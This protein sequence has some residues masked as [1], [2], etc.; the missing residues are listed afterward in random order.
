ML[1]KYFRDWDNRHR[2][3]VVE[4]DDGTIGAGFRLWYLQYGRLLIY[5][6]AEAGEEVDGL[7]IHQF[8]ESD[9]MNLLDMSFDPYSRPTRDVDE[10][11]RM[12]YRSVI[13]I[14]D[15]IL[16]MVL[17]TPTRSKCEDNKS[18]AKG[19]DPRPGGKAQAKG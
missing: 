14:G 17:S 12:S 9:I 11:G 6:E 4:V 18:K 15:Y 19:Q 1:D 2:C 13:G 10:L 3:L 16:D 5:V 8:G 7:H